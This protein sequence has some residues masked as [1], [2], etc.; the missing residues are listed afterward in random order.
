METTVAFGLLAVLQNLFLLR[1]GFDARFIGLVVGLGQLVWAAAVLPAG[2]LSNPL[3]LRNSLQL[4]LTGLGIALLLL[5][6]TRPEL[7]WRMWLL[8]SQGIMNLGVAFITVNI[9]PYLMAVTG[10]QERRQPLPAFQPSSRP[11]PSWAASWPA[12]CRTYWQVSWG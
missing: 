8:A 11:R 7:Q 5:V 10:K 1:L 4:G 6:E 12:C 3:G 9:A 2:L